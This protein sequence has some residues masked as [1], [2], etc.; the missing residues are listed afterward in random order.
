MEV[1]ANLQ[2]TMEA[3]NAKL[4]TDGSD[5]SVTTN[6]YRKRAKTG[7]S[8]RKKSQTQHELSS[9]SD[10]DQEM[11]KPPDPTK[12]EDPHNHPRLEAGIPMDTGASEL[13]GGINDEDIHEIM[14]HDDNPTKN[15]LLLESSS[16]QAEL[17]D[18]DL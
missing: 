3:L 2:K 12:N 7:Q 8:P 18:N 14:S 4:D 10:S 6:S 5:T 9:D 17:E 15:H 1:I 11:N 16:Q 13:N